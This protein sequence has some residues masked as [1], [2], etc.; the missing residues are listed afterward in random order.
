[1][2]RLLNTLLNVFSETSRLGKGG[3]LLK[4]KVMKLFFEGEGDLPNLIGTG[5][6]FDG[7]FIFTFSF[8]LEKG[9][10]LV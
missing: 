3:H 2:G 7:E 4:M 9:W 10:I 5:K 1:M 6:C 8:F